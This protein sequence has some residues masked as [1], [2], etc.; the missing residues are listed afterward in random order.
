M[1]SRMPLSPHELSALAGEI[2][3]TAQQ[4]KWVEA[5]LKLLIREV[6][7]QKKLHHLVLYPDLQSRRYVRQVVIGARWQNQLRQR[8]RIN[9]FFPAKERG[10]PRLLYA[11]YLMVKLGEIYVRATG[12]KPTRGGTSGA[13]SRFERFA[14]P[15][16]DS[17]GIPNF[18]NR[19]RAYIRWRK[20]Q[21]L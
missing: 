9:L 1:K 10:R 13:I 17:I 18:R 2:C 15:C 5:S 14:E 8:R 21:G 16:F 11:D 3:S 4:K 19:V 6:E 7:K 12:K 20:Y